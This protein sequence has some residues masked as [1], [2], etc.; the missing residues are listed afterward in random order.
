MSPLAFA[1][2]RPT[3]GL[4]QPPDPLPRACQ[5]LLSACL[6]CTIYQRL[7]AIWTDGGE[8]NA[9]I[10]LTLKGGPDTRADLGADVVCMPVF[11]DL[12]ERNCVFRAGAVTAMP[13]V[14]LCLPLLLRR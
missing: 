3:C 1:Q 8:R 9:F 12:L 11:E 13:L 5:S 6:T 10:S 14:V 4:Q 2:G 7:L